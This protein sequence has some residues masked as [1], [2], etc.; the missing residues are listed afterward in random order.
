MEGL[1]QA[2]KGGYAG[3]EPS[4]GG[5]VAQAVRWQEWRPGIQ[6]ELEQPFLHNFEDAN[7]V[8]EGISSS[9]S[10]AS[11]HHLSNCTT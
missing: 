6:E 9:S 1:L 4:G 5:K 7:F 8:K 3:C 2:L 10:I 11:D